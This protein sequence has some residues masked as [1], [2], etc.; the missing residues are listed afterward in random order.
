MQH[1]LAPEGQQS[2][3]FE[4]QELQMVQAQAEAYSLLLPWQK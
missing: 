1:R 2:A 4:E 3:L